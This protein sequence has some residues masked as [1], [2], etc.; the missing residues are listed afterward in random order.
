MLSPME[1]IR[2]KPIE[3]TTEK[4]I[5]GWEGTGLPRVFEAI[6]KTREEGGSAMEL[7]ENFREGNKTPLG[8]DSAGAMLLGEKLNQAMLIEAGEMDMSSMTP[9]LD[10]V[11]ASKRLLNTIRIKMG[12]EAE[13]MGPESIKVISDD[14]LPCL[15]RGRH[16]LQERR[17][18]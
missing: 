6:K 14:I 13:A 9:T 7:L 5:G 10:A 16:T 17:A 1:Q 3:G 12:R 4:L 11:T 8:M 15:G 2:L 18:S